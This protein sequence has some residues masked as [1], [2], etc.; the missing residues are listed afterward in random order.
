MTISN[1]KFSIEV[2]L[3]DTANFQNL[4]K[5]LILKICPKLSKYAKV[6]IRKILELYSYQNAKTKIFTTLLR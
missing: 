5:M 2:P 1:R 3:V 6:Q 4:T